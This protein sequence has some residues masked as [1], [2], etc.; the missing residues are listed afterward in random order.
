LESFDA[1]EESFFE[2]VEHP[3]GSQQFLMKLTEE[4]RFVF[5]K[6]ARKAEKRINL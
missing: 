4:K 3:R 1:K 2:K 5:A 6:T